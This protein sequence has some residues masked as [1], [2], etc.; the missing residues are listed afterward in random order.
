MG[1]RPPV[2]YI[3]RTREQYARLG[4]DDY[5]WA[6]R[7][8][9]PPWRPLAKPVAEA[10]LALVASGGA[11]L[12]GQVAVHWQD[13]T[14]IRLVPSDE[15][16]SDV[17]VTHFA[18]DLV[19]ARED[20]NIV[21]PVD[22]LRELGGDGTLGSLAPQAVACMGG[23]YS[24][25]RAEQELAPAVVEAVSDMDGPSVDLVLLVPV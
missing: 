18:Y 16:A 14:G 10:N 7:L 3:A 5:R 20:P 9:T 13:D 22:R 24:V 1:G 11:Y 25:R 17:R 21:F 2:D 8:D 23:I 15:P 19:P 6:E 4:Y 12:Q